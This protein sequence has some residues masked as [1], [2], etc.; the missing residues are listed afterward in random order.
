M[1]MPRTPTAPAVSAVW[2]TSAGP[3]GLL[4]II[5]RP[6]NGRI[7]AY[8]GLRVQ[9]PQVHGVPLP[10]TVYQVPSPRAVGVPETGKGYAT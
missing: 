4:K 7:W 10:D 3:A 8:G 2:G 6:M 1:S 9:G 5:L